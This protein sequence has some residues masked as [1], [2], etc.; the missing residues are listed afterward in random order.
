M[1]K[2][3]LQAGFSAVELLIT[4]FIAAA[5]IGVGYQL[6]S[7]IIDDGSEARQR[8][9]ASNTAYALLRRYSP[10]ATD[11]CSSIT[12]TP[13][14]A[15]P[16]GTA[17]SNASATVTYACPFGTS[18]STTK[19]TVSVKYGNPQQEVIHATYVND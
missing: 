2:N 6:Y 10:Q 3:S 1:R 11:P 7:I 17:L 15:I 8:A 9:V 4:L 5:F 18:A 12:P 19:V 13:S 14:P 16:S